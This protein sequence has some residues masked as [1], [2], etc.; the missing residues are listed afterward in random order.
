MK[1]KASFPA[2]CP[3]YRYTIRT[4]RGYCITTQA[5]LVHIVGAGEFSWEV[6]EETTSTFFTEQEW[7]GD[8]ALTFGVL[9][10]IFIFVGLGAIYQQYCC[11]AENTRNVGVVAMA[12]SLVGRIALVLIMAEGSIFLAVSSRD[13]DLSGAALGAVLYKYASWVLLLTVV[14]GDGICAPKCWF[15]EED[16]VQQLQLQQQQLRQLF[17]QL[18]QQEQEQERQ[19][20]ER[21]ERQMRRVLLVLRRVHPAQGTNVLQQQHRQQHQH[22]H[23]QEH[24]VGV[25]IWI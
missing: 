15:T 12:G 5:N 10:L 1:S 23:P 24:K 7:N 21:H 8:D 9:I 2:F 11:A 20:R 22:Q 14:V 18:L 25:T 4:P 6:E 16:C 19:D 13:D 17:R 3:W